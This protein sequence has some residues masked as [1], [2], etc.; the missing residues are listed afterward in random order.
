[1]IRRS[2]L[3]EFNEKIE[4][5]LCGIEPFACGRS[6]HREP[7]DLPVLAYTDNFVEVLLDEGV[8]GNGLWDLF[9]LPECYRA[10]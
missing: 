3:L 2:H 8:H 1:M 4:I 9:A 6:E 7:P 5:A 10:A